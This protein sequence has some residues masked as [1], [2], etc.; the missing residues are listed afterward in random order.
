M[1]LSSSSNLAERKCESLL[2]DS[3]DM[4]YLIFGFQVVPSVINGA[5]SALYFI[6]WGKGLKLCGPLR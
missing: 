4:F 3:C 5:I 6:L 2:Y 1:R